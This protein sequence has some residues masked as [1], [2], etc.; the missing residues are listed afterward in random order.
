MSAKAK[1]P[2]IAAKNYLIAGPGDHPC[3]NNL[4]LV[5]TDGEGRNRS[6][7]Y[8]RDGIKKKMGFGLAGCRETL[9]GRC[10]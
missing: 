3:G 4:Y 5:V 8:Q 10:A 1:K 6:F 7:R 2:G 9:S